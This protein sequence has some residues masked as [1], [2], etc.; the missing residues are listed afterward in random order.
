LQPH[1]TRELLHPSLGTPHHATTMP[2][3]KAAGVAGAPKAVDRAAA[4]D[5]ATTASLAVDSPQSSAR[6]RAALLSRQYLDR[7]PEPAR[8]GLVI[9]LSFSLD[10]LG[11]ALLDRLTNDELGGIVTVAESRFEIAVWAAWK[12][13][14][15]VSISA[16]PVPGV[17]TP[18]PLPAPPP[19]IHSRP[20]CQPQI[21][22]KGCHLSSAQ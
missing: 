3:S 1:T 12:V 15:P 6:G 20:P 2:R 11:R 21:G 9:A 10:A 5:S 17:P 16:F 7:L 14:V 8:L 4:A 18:G 22:L 13:Y 19:P